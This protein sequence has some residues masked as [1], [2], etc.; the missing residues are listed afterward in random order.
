MVLAMTLSVT[1]RRG[2]PYSPVLH[3]HPSSFLPRKGV[4]FLISVA[5]VE[6]LP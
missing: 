3:F 5:L 4:Y 1:D 2:I 6:I